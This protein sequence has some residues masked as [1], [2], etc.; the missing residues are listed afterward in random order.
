MGISLS[1]KIF[2][3]SSIHL[4][5]MKCSLFIYILLTEYIFSQKFL[6]LY[7]HPFSD[8]TKTTTSTPFN[9]QIVEICWKERKSKSVRCYCFCN[10]KIFSLC[11]ET[12]CLLICD[13]SRQRLWL[14]M[15]TPIFVMAS[16][17]CLKHCTVWHWQGIDE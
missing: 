11:Q 4:H 16:V 8:K 6:E 10:S 12:Q 2:W 9:F 5:L 15:V 14:D 7:F 13:F 17:Y 3:F 1:V